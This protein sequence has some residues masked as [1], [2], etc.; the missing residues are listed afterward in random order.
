M[1]KTILKFLVERIDLPM[2][3]SYQIKKDRPN[4]YI[5]LAYKDEMTGK[6]KTTGQRR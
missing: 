5:V 1:G 4:Y 2:T 3:A 6:N